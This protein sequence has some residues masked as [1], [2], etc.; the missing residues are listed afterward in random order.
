MNDD[1]EKY[2]E[3]AM[4]VDDTKPSNS[5]KSEPFRSDQKSQLT[6]RIVNTSRSSNRVWL[7]KVRKNFAVLFFDIFEAS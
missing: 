4:E 6:D 1:D 2:A 3:L 7:V 5:S